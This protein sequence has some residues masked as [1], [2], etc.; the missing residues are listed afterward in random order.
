MGTIQKGNIK[1]ICSSRQC[2]LDA[3][4]YT[5]EGLILWY[6]NGKDKNCVAYLCEEFTGIKRSTSIDAIDD[7]ETLAD[8]KLRKMTFM[9]E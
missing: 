6:E 4:D 8:A 7:A 3:R 9:S 1:A 5:Y 2:G